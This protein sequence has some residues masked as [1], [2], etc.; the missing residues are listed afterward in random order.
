MLLKKIV[1]ISVQFSR[2]VVSNSLW[3]Y[4]LQHARPPCPSWTPRAYWTHVHW[5]GDAIQPSHLLS[6]PSPLAFNLAQHQGLFRWVS[7]LHLCIRWPKNWSFRNSVLVSVVYQHELAIGIHTS[8]PLEPPSH[9]PPFPTP[10]RCYRG[11]GFPESVIQQIF[12]GYL[13]YIW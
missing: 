1:Y 6:S 13:L 11:F 5:V 4:G 10:L 3:P 9:L 2:S 8:P 7:S 12:I